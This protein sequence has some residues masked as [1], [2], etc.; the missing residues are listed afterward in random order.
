MNCREITEFLEQ[1]VADELSPDVLD[2]FQ[3]HVDACGNC[4]TY[5]KQYRAVIAV[6]KESYGPTPVEPPPV[7]DELVQLI[8]DTLERSR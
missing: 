3:R 4:V 8:L 6:A 1:Y 5:M 7:P 2:E